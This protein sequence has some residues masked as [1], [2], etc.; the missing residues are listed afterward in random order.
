MF[1][2]TNKELLNHH[3]ALIAL[4]SAVLSKRVRKTMFYDDIEE[5]N[6]KEVSVS[7]LNGENSVYGIMFNL[8][9]EDALNE[10]SI[11]KVEKIVGIRR[12]EKGSY[13]VTGEDYVSKVPVYYV[14]VTFD[15]VYPTTK[16]NMQRVAGI[17]DMA[18]A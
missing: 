10:H 3:D 17:I 1:K 16:S 5:M 18:L 9:T 7:L 2:K 13:T 8:K 15:G 14:E 4:Q 11:N 12:V 6:G